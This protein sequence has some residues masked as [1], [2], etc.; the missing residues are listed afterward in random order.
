[1]QQVSNNNI[2][3][4]TGLCSVISVSSS[5]DGHPGSMCRKSEKGEGGDFP[6]H[7][8]PPRGP[9][10][11]VH[12]RSGQKVICPSF[13]ITSRSHAAVAGHGMEL[14]WLH[15]GGGAQRN[16]CHRTN[17]PAGLLWEGGRPCT[18]KS[19]FFEPTISLTSWEPQKLQQT[20]KCQQTTSRQVKFLAGTVHAC[21]RHQG[22][23]QAAKQRNSDVWSSADGKRWERESRKFQITEISISWTYFLLVRNLV[24][25][26][27]TFSSVQIEDGTGRD[28][29][30]TF[31]SKPQSFKRLFS[32]TFNWTIIIKLPQPVFF[33]YTFKY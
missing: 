25:L 20:W 15:E 7:V 27:I 21:C 4:I 33:L 22:A 1:M 13:G 3:G 26:E 2:E 19:F 6:P 9:C 23:V 14:I 31:Y 28:M 11:P 30:C 8:G 10:S 17:P 32:Q 29:V 24:Y 12:L 18:C 16:D 5:S